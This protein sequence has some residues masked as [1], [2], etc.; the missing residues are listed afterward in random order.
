MTLEKVKELLAEHLE[1]DA[2]EITEAT[3][4]EDLGVDSLDAVEIM[5]E[6]EDEF[7]IEIKPAEAGK[8]VKELVAYIDSKKA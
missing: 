4:F 5:M 7:G 6:M 3:T 1:M 8:S 2:A